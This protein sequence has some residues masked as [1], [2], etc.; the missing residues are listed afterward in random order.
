MRFFK[1]LCFLFLIVKSQDTTELATTEPTAPTTTELIVT[2]S[3]T[4]D[5]TTSTQTTSTE[6]KT[7]EPPTTLVIETTATTE[8][9][10]GII[11]LRNIAPNL[12]QDSDDG[13]ELFTV[14]CSVNNG[15]IIS[16]NDACKTSQ[17]PQLPQNNDGLFITS[18]NLELDE[19]LNFD[20]TSIEDKCK[21]TESGVLSIGFNDCGIASYTMPSGEDYSVFT[22]YANHRQLIGDI[23]TSLMD[24]NEIQ[25]RLSL[26]DLDST[27]SLG[28]G[29]GLILSN[30]DEETV[31]HTIT[32]DSLVDDFN[33]ELILGTISNDQFTKLSTGMDVDVGQSIQIK[34]QHS[35][36][37]YLFGFFDC[38]VSGGNKKIELFN[39][40]CPKTETKIIGLNWLSY[41]SFD[42]N[43]F[44][45]ENSNSL[46]FSC[47]VAVYPSEDS[48]PPPC[49]ARRRRRSLKQPIK[50]SRKVTAT[51]QVYDDRNDIQSGA[52][53]QYGAILATLIFFFMSI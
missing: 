52:S 40:Y 46:T 42:L 25:C 36:S 14:S 2:E 21:F 43:V 33:L 1:K 22:V 29:D 31:S 15:F 3:T 4:V 35:Q 51:V 6:F 24:Q 48:L 28:G 41:A 38:E 27:D 53:P 32:S 47:A 45:I 37:S 49:D 20:T 5:T 26:I 17:Y 9:M 10:N 18:K 8:I 12:N 30:P 23:S 13:C 50:S 11:A 19:N 34:L 7:T 44:R 16:L 39:G